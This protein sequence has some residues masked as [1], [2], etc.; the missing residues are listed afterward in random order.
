MKK[1]NFIVL[2]IICMLL[3]A[4][5]TMALATPQGNMNSVGNVKMENQVGLYTD[6]FYYLQTELKNLFDE[7]K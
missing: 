5:G 3:L 7:I 4:E 1:I 2:A 6:D